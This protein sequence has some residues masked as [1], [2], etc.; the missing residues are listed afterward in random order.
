MTSPL[1]VIHSSTDPASTEALLS[2]STRLATMS[3]QLDELTALVTGQ[4]AQLTAL[5][6]AL[7]SKQDAMAAAIAALEA[8][9]ASAA[10][11]AALQAVIDALRA[12]N[13]MLDETTA[14]VID[15]PVPSD[16]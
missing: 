7:D 11:P 4:T 5:Q 9:L 15:T 16:G 14:D 13:K 2:I 1:V 6:T 3:A 10:D 8:A 12:N